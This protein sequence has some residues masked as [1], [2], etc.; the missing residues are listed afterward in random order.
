MV[1]HEIKRS[2]SEKRVARRAFDAALESAF[3]QIMAELKSKAAAVTTASEMWGIEEYLRR[4]RREI[5]DTFDYRCSQ[6]PFGFVQLQ[7]C[8]DEPERAGWSGDKLETI[9]RG[10]SHMRRT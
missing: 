9:R 7:G 3:A 10:L 4:R 2:V 8:P 1:P 5:E 6:L